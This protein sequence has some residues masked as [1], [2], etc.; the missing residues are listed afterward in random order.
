[1]TARHGRDHIGYQP[2]QPHLEFETATAVIT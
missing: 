2:L 1:M